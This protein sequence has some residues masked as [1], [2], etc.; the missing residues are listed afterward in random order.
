MKESYA[1][2]AKRIKEMKAFGANRFANLPARRRK[3]R[4]PSSLSKEVTPAL[5]TDH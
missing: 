3:E 2:H 5:T 1:K 4:A